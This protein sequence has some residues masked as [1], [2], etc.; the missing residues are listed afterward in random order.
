MN[1]IEQNNE[2]INGI[3]ETF[4]IKITS[5]EIN[6]LTRLLAKLKAHGIIKKSS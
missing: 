6:K 4:E 5:K 3:L 2:K 1:I